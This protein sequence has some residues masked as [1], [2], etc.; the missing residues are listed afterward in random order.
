MRLGI[1]IGG[2]KT[3]A[4]VVGADGETV[5]LRQVPSGRGEDVVEVAVRTAFEAM[6]QSGGPSSVASV[7]A[8]A[9]GV[10]DHERGVVRHAVNLGVVEL[11]LADALSDR[12]GHRVVVEN[13]VKSAAL[14]AFLA[15]G[16]ASD[17][18]FGY[19]NLGTGLAAAVLRAG[20]LDRGPDGLL[21]E[22][23][24]VPIGGDRPCTCGQTGCLETVASGAALDARLGAWRPGLPTL[25]DRAAAGDGEAMA[26]AEELVRGIRI[27]LQLLV[28]AGGCDRIVV[29]GGL[30][31]LGEPLVEALRASIAE[32]D[33]ASRFH[34][35][36]GLWERTAFVHSHVPL[37]A[38]GAAALPASDG[39]AA[40]V[41]PPEVVAVNQ[42]R[43]HL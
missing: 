27:A 28:V 11:D 31:G 8:C 38:L 42:P 26:A 29:G 17:G 4:V 25:L 34:A 39:S 37:A 20:R 35:A 3:A 10:V 43:S 19:L 41:V 13:D 24:H 14:G 1:D 5:A 30:T 22:I 18:T 12:L 36:L 9:P 6:E 2:T 7:G 23:G 40:A 33:R 15:T 16:A 32:A 21:G